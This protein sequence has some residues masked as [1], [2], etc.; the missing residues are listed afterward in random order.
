MYHGFS[1][2]HMV[3]RLIPGQISPENN[4][5]KEARFE[6]NLEKQSDHFFPSQDDTTLNGTAAP[7]LRS[8]E[9]FRV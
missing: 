4:G 6:T 9:E 5:G 7:W 8:A 2:Q 1:V 3:W